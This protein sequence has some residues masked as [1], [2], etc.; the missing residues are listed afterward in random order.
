M[1]ATCSQLAAQVM[2]GSVWL[3]LKGW[4][5][6]ECCRMQLAA[7]TWWTRKAAGLLGKLL[8]RIHHSASY[9]STRQAATCSALAMLH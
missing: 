2:S 3:R 9:G 1:H 8:L 6:E 4:Y 7:A 5:A